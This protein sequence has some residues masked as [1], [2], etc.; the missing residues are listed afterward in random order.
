MAQDVGEQ[1]LSCFWD[2]ASLEQAT[3]VSAATSLANAVEES[4]KDVP[5]KAST[6]TLDESLAQCS[7]LS[8][9]VLQRLCRGL[10]SSREGARQGFS[11][12]LA[13][14]LQKLSFV[15]PSQAVELLESTLEKPR[16]QKGEE[17]RDYL[18][19][20]LFGAGAIARSRGKGLGSLSAAEARPLAALILSTGQKKA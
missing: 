19:A 8:S 11:V 16:G 1:V 14:V 7:Q 13:L 4:Q 15:S 3:Q 18:L 6:A 17:V 2:L 20:L 10:A 5:T 9:Y 12:G